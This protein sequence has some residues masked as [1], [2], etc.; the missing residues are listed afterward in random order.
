MTMLNRLRFICH[1]HGVRQWILTFFM[2][3]LL[4]LLLLPLTHTSL[5]FTNHS[6]SAPEG[7]YVRLPGSPAIGEYAIVRMPVAVNI[8][9][10]PV[11]VGHLIVKKKIGE[12]NHP[13]E[14]T[15]TE[16]IT[17]VQDTLHSTT[18]TR[19]YHIHRELSYLPELSPGKYSVPS[20]Y[21]L[22]LNDPDDSLD[23]RYLGPIPNENIVG[24]VHL[25]ISFD[26]LH[27]MEEALYDLWL[28]IA[29]FEL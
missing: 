2:L 24:R 12:T 25:L 3:L 13:Y 23:S 9:F 1:P 21:T 6:A 4:L 11:D 15:S 26:T 28:K 18:Q 17:E 19:H 7:V 20:G 5:F 14:V 29:K 27:S 22:F 8:P 10:E 16:L